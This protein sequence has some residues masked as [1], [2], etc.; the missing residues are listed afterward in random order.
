M[1]EDGSMRIRMK[2]QIL[3]TH[4]DFHTGQSVAWP[5]VGEEVTVSAAEGAK[6]VAFGSAIPVDTRDAD[7]EKRGPG[8]P[9]K[10]S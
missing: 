7:V 2:E 1:A 8:P 5:P 10:D 3:G 9:R 6:R 4:P